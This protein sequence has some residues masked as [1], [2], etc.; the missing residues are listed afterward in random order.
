[1]S[2]EQA[3]GARAAASRDGVADNPSFAM[4]AEC[5]RHMTGSSGR[6]QRMRKLQ[7]AARLEAWQHLKC[8]PALRRELMDSEAACGSGGNSTRPGW[9]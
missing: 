1:L 6:G 8:S 3:A 5:G 4:L 9:R 2:Q 7:H